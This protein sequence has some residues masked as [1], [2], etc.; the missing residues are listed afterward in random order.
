LI[1]EK[2]GCGAVTATDTT[3]QYVQGAVAVAAEAEKELKLMVGG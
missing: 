3:V 2:R 1:S